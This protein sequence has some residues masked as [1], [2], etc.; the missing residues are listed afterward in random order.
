MQ[1]KA[2]PSPSPVVSYPD[3]SRIV[4]DHADGLPGHPPHSTFLL[5][6]LGMVLAEPVHADRD[7]PPFPRSARDGFACR[8]ADLTTGSPLKVIGSIRA[9]DA[10]TLEINSGQAVEIMTGA[11]V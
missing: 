4:R 3:A 10:V 6:A 11:P 1:M 9:G 5:E 7:Q 2:P 8:A